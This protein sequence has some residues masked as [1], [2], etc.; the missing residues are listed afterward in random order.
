MNNHKIHKVTIGTQAFISYI[1]LK[2][3]QSNS[4]I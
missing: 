1:G 3:S 2:E 4:A